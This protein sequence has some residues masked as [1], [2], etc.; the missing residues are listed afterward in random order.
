MEDIKRLSSK[1]EYIVIEDLRQNFDEIDVDVDIMVRNNFIDSYYI[2]IDCNYKGN[3]DSWDSSTF[4]THLNRIS[5]LVHTAC[6]NYV[7]NSEGKLKRHTMED[8][9]HIAEPRIDKINYIIDDT[10]KFSFNVMVVPGY[11]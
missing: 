9:I 8:N 10:H 7:L 1:I 5:D 2:M 4:A 3:I 11:E 6:S